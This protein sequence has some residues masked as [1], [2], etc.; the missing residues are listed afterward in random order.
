[1]KITIAHERFP[2]KPTHLILIALATLIAT[3]AILGFGKRKE[4]LV[5]AD[6]FRAVWKE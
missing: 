1:V 4:E 6:Q 2:V 3:N 5:V